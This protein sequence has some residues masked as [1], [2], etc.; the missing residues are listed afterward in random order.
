M[1]HN[2]Y[3]SIYL[4]L[5]LFPKH[6]NGSYQ[7]G[8]YAREYEIRNGTN[9]LLLKHGTHNTLRYKKKKRKERI[10]D[11]YSNAQDIHSTVVEHPQVQWCIAVYP[12]KH[13][14]ESTGSS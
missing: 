13:G 5:E 6:L 10:I 7:E 1:S 3:T 8:V 14:V 2:I 4:N 11:Y 9:F 12:G